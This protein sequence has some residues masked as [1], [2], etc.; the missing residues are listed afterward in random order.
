MSN[1][2]NPGRG[3]PHRLRDAGVSNINEQKTKGMENS[4]DEEIYKLH[5]IMFKWQMK[6]V[7]RD[8]HLG[9]KLRRKPRTWWLEMGGEGVYAQEGPQE[10]LT[11]ARFGPGCW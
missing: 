1:Q 7:S 4:G 2:R 9:E 10:A 11:T 8:T 3:Q 6:P 5:P